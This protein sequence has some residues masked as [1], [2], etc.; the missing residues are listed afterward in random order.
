MTYN[1]TV[2][3]A[4]TDYAVA[5]LE[6]FERVCDRVGTLRQAAPGWGM[7]FA[8]EATVLQEMYLDG[9]EPPF[10]FALDI[11]TTTTTSD[12]TPTLVDKEALITI[13]FSGTEEGATPDKRVIHGYV[14][15]AVLT[16]LADPATPRGANQ[17]RL[18]IYPWFWFLYYSRH[19]RHWMNA[20]L[21]TIFS[22]V[23]SPYGFEENQHWAFDS[24]PSGTMSYVV[25]HQ[26]SDLAFLFDLLRRNHLS[27]Y[28]THATDG[29]VLHIGD[30]SQTTFWQAETDLNH[31]FEAMGSVGDM[32]MNVAVEQKTTP[33]VSKVANRRRALASTSSFGVVGA[34]SPGE[35]ATGTLSGGKVMFA[36][37]VPVS[38]N[39]EAEGEADARLALEE[40]PG[41]LF[42]GESRSLKVVAGGRVVLHH[43]FDRT[44]AIE[45]AKAV[46]RRLHHKLDQ[47]GYSSWFEATPLG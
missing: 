36:Y 47:H 22:D 43:P 19:N 46:V 25:Q 14:H 39:S 29:H 33:T 37:P 18:D 15:R 7:G 41:R 1:A 2:T 20:A 26:Q 38:S 12:L 24:T 9:H 32:L 13:D 45:G 44:G 5:R 42:T 40:M 30:P 28:F 17:Y 35:P 31:V 11:S 10:H 8:P 21:T 16:R 27:A 6:G 34:T 3:V 23:C 4:G